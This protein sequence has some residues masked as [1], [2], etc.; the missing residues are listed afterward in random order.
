MKMEDAVYDELDDAK[1]EIENLKEKYRVKVESAESLKRAHNDQLNKNN[2]ASSKLEKLTQVLYQKEDELSNA[3]QMLGELKS[4][5]AEKESIV[6]HLSSSHDKL[7]SDCSEKLRKCEEE[8]EALASALD[9]ANAR[10]IDHEQKIRALGQ[11]IEGF[12]RLLDFSEKKCLET[13]K[14]ITASRKSEA[15]EDEYFVLDEERR[16][17]KDELKWKKEQF[18]HLEE[19]HK[20]LH[21]DFKTKEKEW[22]TEKTVLLDDISSLQTKLES[23][24]RILQDHEH[25]LEMCNRA[26]AH[27][28]SK[29]K[30]LDLQLSETRSSFD[31]VCAEYDEA[32]SDFENWNAQKDRDITNLRSSLGTKEI[33]YKE[34]EYQLKKMDQ[35]KQELSVSLKELQEDRIREAGL[36]YSSSKLQNKLKSLELTHKECSTNLKAKESE[37]RSETEKLSEEL[38]SCRLELKN[39]D[40]SLKELNR[41]LDACDSLMLEM[42]LL[43]QETS[44]I[45]LVLKLGFSEA[46]CMNLRNKEV[47]ENMHELVEQLEKKKATLNSVLKDL[48]DERKNAVN[49]SKKVET[50]EEQ[51]Y[52]MQKEVD[53]LTG[54]LEE[55]KIR[56]VQSEEEAVRLWSDCANTELYEKSCEANEI[57]FELQIW[58]S[59]A[60]QMEMDL[61]RNLETRRE[62]EASLFAQMEVEMNLKQER[63]DL[64]RRLEEKEREIEDLQQQII[65]AETARNAEEDKVSARDEA[66]NGKNTAKTANSKI[67][68]QDAEEDEALPPQVGAGIDENNPEGK[69]NLRKNA[70]ENKASDRDNAENN[71]NTPGTT[72][73]IYQLVEEKDR[74]IYGMQRLVASLEKEFE[75]STLSFS[76]KLSRMQ[77]ER[78]TLPESWE[79]IK[80]DEVLKEMEMQEKNTVIVELENDLRDLRRIVEKQE[81]ALLSSEKKIQEI[82]VEL[83]KEE[84][85][86]QKLEHELETKIRTSDET[87]KDLTS[88]KEKLESAIRLMSEKMDKLTMVEVDVKLMES[89]GKIVEAFD[90]SSGDD[91]V[92]DYCVNENHVNNIMV[93]KRAEGIHDGERS[94]LRAIN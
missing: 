42:E 94:P 63:E 62:V 73:R 76:S 83:E 29:W 10:N 14:K 64:S 12:K 69:N 46:C 92:E 15:E 80:S 71:E 60:E 85:K 55:S 8:K 93:M 84:T 2:E 89:L 35:E 86:V 90:N 49:L 38:N 32:K 18:V 87:I 81:R 37:W 51:Q 77:K 61:K 23:Q 11:E 34:M 3:R 74:R 39:R 21:N 53:R 68:S 33:L 54:M 47:H 25:R 44:L 30:L 50:L 56:R 52:H 82:L 67:S 88:E 28:E 66:E 57:E 41:E 79:S 78:K 72:E 6:R 4:S 26:L 16:K 9:D 7:R 17:F 22:E 58:K 5:L 91:E 19:A 36:S 13:A 65:D 1:A 45:L 31:S 24:T 75:S 48:D 20:K 40:A 43:N 59:I 27:A 70:E